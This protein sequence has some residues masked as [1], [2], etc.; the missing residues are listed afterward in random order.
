MTHPIIVTGPQRAGSHIATH[1]IAQETGGVFVD[2]LDYSLSLPPKAVVQA[3]FLLKSVL[4]LSYIM[5][6]A[7]FAFMYRNPDDIVASLKRIEWYKDYYKDESFYPVYVQHCYQ[8]IDL[9]K[10]TLQPERW[11]DVH[12]ESLMFHPSFVKD[13]TDFT[14]KQYLPDKP[15]GPTTWRNDEYIT[16]VKERL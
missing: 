2:E 8:T 5:P 4:E 1:I 15:V 13:R 11:F 6:D 7:T 16:A 14:V 10:Q 12:Y 3:P 9:L